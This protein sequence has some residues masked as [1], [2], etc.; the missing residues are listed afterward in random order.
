MVD[1]LFAAWLR[2]GSSYKIWWICLLE[3]LMF[4]LLCSTFHLG[5]VVSK[6]ARKAYSY[7]SKEGKRLHHI[8]V[9]RRDRCCCKCTWTE[10]RS[11]TG[12]SHKLAGLRH[13]YLTVSDTE[14]NFLGWRFPKGI[15][16]PLYGDCLWSASLQTFKENQ[17]W[18]EICRLFLN[19]C[20]VPNKTTQIFIR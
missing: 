16:F 15:S 13:I 17:L 18:N 2:Q 10:L 3:L 7:C 14:Q 5:W 1:D 4:S 8:V 12:R 6:H 9:G 11:L 19:I 20:S